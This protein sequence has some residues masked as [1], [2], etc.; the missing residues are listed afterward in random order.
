MK[1]KQTL[2]EGVNVVLIRLRMVVGMLMNLP[3]LKWTMI[4]LS[5][6]DDNVV[7]FYS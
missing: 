2:G 7:Q 1:D 3:F 6:Y 4:M 5:F